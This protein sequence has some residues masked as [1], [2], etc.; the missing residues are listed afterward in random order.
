M[1]SPTMLLVT[2]TLGL[3]SS[4]GGGGGGDMVGRKGMHDNS[5]L[6][7]LKQGNVEPFVQNPFSDVSYFPLYY[8]SPSHHGCLDLLND[9][10]NCV[11]R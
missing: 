6:F 4:G 5:Y 10:G 8:P 7:L 9:L 11:T 3:E 2:S 1:F